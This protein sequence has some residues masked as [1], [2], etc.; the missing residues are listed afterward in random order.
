MTSIEFGDIK[1]GDR[2]RRSQLA[3]STETAVSLTVAHICGGDC[4]T[5]CNETHYTAYAT[6]ELLERPKPE[7]KPGQVWRDSL[8]GGQYLT[9]ANGGFIRIDRPPTP[10]WWLC[11][12]SWGD[13]RACLE[14]V[15]EAEIGVRP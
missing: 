7:F 8:N 3:G 11:P 14:Y 5:D 15:G 13:P 10:S 4:L 1:V 9:V 6:W 2:V 12:A